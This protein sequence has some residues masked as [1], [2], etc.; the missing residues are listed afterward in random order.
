MLLNETLPPHNFASSSEQATRKPWSAPREFRSKKRS[1]FNT[2]KPITRSRHR[3][4]SIKPKIIRCS[5]RE[6]EVDC[7]ERMGGL[8]VTSTQLRV[9]TER[10]STSS[11]NSILDRF[12]RYGYPSGSHYSQ[13]TRREAGKFIDDPISGMFKGHRKITFTD[14]EKAWICQL[15]RAKRMMQQTR[16]VWLLRIDR[17]T[18]SWDE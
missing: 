7:N 17:W 13:R 2:S 14:R 15:K 12:S 11:S 4:C 8:P 16:E 3:N 1:M 10:W 5:K 18:V 9:C 6:R